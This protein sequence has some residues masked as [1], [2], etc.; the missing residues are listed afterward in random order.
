MGETVKL[1]AFK[2][3]TRPFSADS[4]RTICVI[5]FGILALL[6][7]SR[8]ALAERAIITSQGPVK[9]LEVSGEHEYL[10]IPY[11]APPIGN[12]RWMPPQLPA[13]FKGL[14]QATQFGNRCTQRLAGV[15]PVLGSEDCLYLNVYVP[16][17]DPPA[18]G[19][20]VM[21]WIHGGALVFGAGSDYD[22]TPL[23]NNGPVIVV[24]VNYRLGLLG[25]FAHPA[26]DSQPPPVGNYG[27]MD[28][29]FALDWVRQNIAAFGGDRT[30]VTIFGESGGGLSVYANLAS[31]TAA[32]LFSRAI[33]ESGAYDQFQNY[34]D[35]IIPLGQAESAGTILVPAGTTIAAQLGCAPQ[36]ASCL[37]AVPAATL[38]E[39]EPTAVY[40][41][42]DGAI[43]SQ[44]PSLAFATGAFNRVPVITGGNH[45]EWRLFVA[46][47]YDA[48]GQPLVTSVDYQRATNA[49][50][51]SVLAP[52]L[53][54]FFYPLA[55]YPSPGIAL[56][57][58]GTDG[59]FACPERNSVR[60]LSAQTPTYAYEFNDENAYLVYDL[61]PSPPY[62][63]ITFP[64]GAAHFTEVPYLFEV[65]STPGIFVPYQKVLS[66]TMIGYWTQFAR[67]G[68]PNSNGAPVWPLYAL[69]AQFESLG[70]TI[71]TE[72]D[73]S[74][75]F[76]HKCSLLWNTF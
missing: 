73:S 12:L 37:R 7:P 35:F 21:V 14:F 57:A 58:S 5:L 4:Q 51:G 33:A 2:V 48:M 27:L 50:W 20:P 22:P 17:V 39:Q 52:I 69:S 9:G 60:L 55:D 26:I 49:L 40:P 67:S 54:G 47:Q 75:D 62:S 46:A 72:L 61:F 16:D 31:P 24:T 15:G 71:G 63:P 76:D 64:L 18:H 65:L 25:F 11:A 56:G 34:F 53:Y 19:F 44:T 41:F 43:L 30:R 6:L 13:Q 29:Q 38:V 68:N 36:T 28:Q 10:G 32:G 59:I 3:S 70:P 45:D 8:V 74:F 42:V 1:R 66:D 23:V